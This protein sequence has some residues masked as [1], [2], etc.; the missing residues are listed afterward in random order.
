MKHQHSDFIRI[1]KHITQPGCKDAYDAATMATLLLCPCSPEAYAFVEHVLEQTLTH[2]K[3]MG[4]RKHKIRATDLLR[5]K[6]GIGAVLGDLLRQATNEKSL[7]FMFRAKNPQ[8]FSGTLCSFRTYQ[9]LE[10]SW[11]ELGLIEV[12]KG[13]R[14]QD[15][16]EGERYDTWGKAGRLRATPKLLSLAQMF[17]ITP[18]TASE[19][20]KTDHGL[21]FPVEVKT[22]SVRATSGKR[23]SKVMPLRPSPRRDHALAQVRD[24]NAFYEQHSFNLPEPPRLKRTFHNGD[25]P[26]FDYDQGGRLYCVSQ[27]NYQNLHKHE[28]T[29]ITIDGKPVAEVDVSSSFPFILHHQCGVPFPVAEDIYSIPYIERLVV[30]KIVVARLGSEDWPTRWPR[31][32]KEE[33]LEATGRRLNKTYKLKEVVKAVKEKISV[34]EKVD[35]RWIGWAK[36]QY[37]ESQAMIRAMMT[38]KDF[39]VVSLPVHDSLIIPNDKVELA[40]EAI[41]EAYTLSFGS[42]PQVKEVI[43]EKE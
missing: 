23:K 14:Y 39:G 16:F 9:R 1:P 43:L 30:K 22:T 5:L 20:F 6:E 37:L 31:G 13:F 29:K 7:G 27:G 24:L 26:G 41:K 8:K 4:R 32:F 17:G 18:E 42:S 34:L 33:Y 38:L 28:R 2:E 12:K 15:D 19:H 11:I 21:S 36:L 25:D 3:D 35:Q 10:E 40:K